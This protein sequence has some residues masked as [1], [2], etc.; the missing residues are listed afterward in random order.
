MSFN[1]E[2]MIRFQTIGDEEIIRYLKT[3]EMFSANTT[4]FEN[5]CEIILKQLKS[6]IYDDKAG[7]REGQS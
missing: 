1:R 2:R 3:I 4:T 7:E 6:N 5:I